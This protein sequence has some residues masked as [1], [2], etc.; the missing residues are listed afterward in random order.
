MAKARDGDAVPVALSLMV[1]EFALLKEED[2]VAFLWFAASAPAEAFKAFNVPRL[3]RLGQI[4]VDTTIVTSKNA[5]L[6]GRISLHADPGGD[7]YLP[8]YYVQQCGLLPVNPNV[9]LTGVRVNDGRYYYA[10][11]SLADI[12][13]SKMDCFR[14]K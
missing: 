4:L 8:R 10:T 1:E 7:A 3:D 5:G 11:S 6:N 12:L 2:P 13:L 14:G 9:S